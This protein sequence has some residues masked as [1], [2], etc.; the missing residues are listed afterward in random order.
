MSRRYTVFTHLLGTAHNPETGGPVWA[1]QDTEPMEG[2]FPTT[3]WPSGMLVKDTHTLQIDP[4]APAG[5]YQF[6]IG[7]YSRI[8][9]SGCR[10]STQPAT[11][12]TTGSCCSP[13]TSSRL[14]S[15]LG[16][17]RSGKIGPQ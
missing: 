12:L 11:S 17:I 5:D 14:R 9:G 2:R 15:L 10:S 13:C 4:A 7:L 8:W 16:V 1:Q 3:E 6:E